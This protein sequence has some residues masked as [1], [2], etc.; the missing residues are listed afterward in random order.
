MN[1]NSKGLERGREHCQGKGYLKPTLATRQ[2]ERIT[3]GLPPLTTNQENVVPQR[4]QTAPTVNGGRRGTS[5][6]YISKCKGMDGQVI[7]TQYPSTGMTLQEYA[8]GGQWGKMAATSSHFG[9]TTAASSGAPRTATAP[10][11][12]KPRQ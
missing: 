7:K 5:R 9:N 11:W 10:C 6:G 2:A 12:R 3:L 8:V 1:K 4:G